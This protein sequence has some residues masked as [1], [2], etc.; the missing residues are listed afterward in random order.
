MS[1]PPERESSAASVMRSILAVAS[2]KA[3][4]ECLLVRD[5]A[6]LYL[7]DSECIGGTRLRQTLLNFAVQSTPSTGVRS[8]VRL[9]AV[10]I[11]GAQGL[12]ISRQLTSSCPS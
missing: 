10:L 12:R 1:K 4:H 3:L 6:L 2:L 9:L 8:A 5:F 7:A 11:R